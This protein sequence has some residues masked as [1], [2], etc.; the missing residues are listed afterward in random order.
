MTIPMPIRQ[1]IRKFEDECRSRSWIA[2]RLGL[3]R[4]TVARYADMEDFSPRPASGRVGSRSGVEPFAR[5]VD[6]WLREDRALPRK[7]RHT[8]QRV[9]DRLAAEQGFTGSYSAVQRWVKHWREMNRSE[10]D[11][12]TQLAWQPGVAQVDFGLAR[13]LIAGAERD[14]HVLVVSFPYSNMRYALALPGENAEC[15]CSGLIT[16]FEHIGR[17]PRVLV[18]DN[19]TGVG[20]RFGRE[21]TM[22]QVFQ[23]FQTH[24]RVH[25]TRFS[26]PVFG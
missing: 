4:N 21:V 15:V 8:A 3:S 7:Q 12:F 22:T 26:Q 6:A 19:A 24:Y 25:E 23:A 14:V 17:V 10:G 20:H 13:A 18:F 1:D 11:G 2:R 5:I 16:L 9:F